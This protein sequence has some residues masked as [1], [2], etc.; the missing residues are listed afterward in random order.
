MV[1]SHLFPLSGS[2][3]IHSSAWWT[4]KTEIKKATTKR[5]DCIKFTLWCKN[6]R[7]G[8]I[9]CQ[10]PPSFEKQPSSRYIF[11]LSIYST[12]YIC[13]SRAIHLAHHCHSFFFPSSASTGLVATFE[14][15]TRIGVLLTMILTVTTVMEAALPKAHTAVLC[16]CR[17]G[18]SRCG[19][20]TLRSSSGSFSNTMPSLPITLL[21]LSIKHVI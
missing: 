9:Q 20:C 15:I 2:Q 3:K 4:L 12:P 16:T 5:T 1:S 14:K 17:D 6:K 18:T 7:I 10:K 13:F 21:S 11:P 19:Y 8:L